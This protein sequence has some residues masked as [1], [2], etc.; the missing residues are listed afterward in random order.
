MTNYTYSPQVESTTTEELIG[1]KAQV[2]QLLAALEEARSSRDYYQ[3]EVVKR[4]MAIEKKEQIIEQKDKRIQSLEKMYLQSKKLNK[5]TDDMI[6][7]PHIQQTRDRVLLNELTKRTLRVSAG[8]DGKWRVSAGELA[9]AINLSKDAIWDGM[10]SLKAMGIDIDAEQIP[11]KG[12]NHKRYV[13]SISQEIKDNPRGAINPDDKGN[14]GGVREAV[15]CPNCGSSRNAHIK[16]NK[17][18]DCSHEWGKISKANNKDAAA[19][20]HDEVVE[21]EA[22]EVQE[23]STQQETL[24]PD[25]KPQRTKSTPTSKSAE[26]AVL[27]DKPPRPNCPMCGNPKDEWEETFEFWFCS[28]CINKKE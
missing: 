13:Y 27:G 22:T 14:Y 5:W 8:A 21:E 10:K 23:P 12:V 9:S 16:M 6:N 24:F 20:I 11:G 18:V 15:L 19:Q 2:D 1:T 7:H 17:C 28:T 3:N 26:T 4:D 25:E